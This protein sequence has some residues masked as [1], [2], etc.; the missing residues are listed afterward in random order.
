[1]KVFAILRQQC[2]FDES[3]LIQ[4][5]CF[6]HYLGI[7]I[8]NV[9]SVKPCCTLNYLTRVGQKLFKGKNDPNIYD[10]AIP[11][12]EFIQGGASL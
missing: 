3:N 12:V 1:V 7:P 6:G 9:I 8:R 2:N 5:F 10:V 11:P 4:N